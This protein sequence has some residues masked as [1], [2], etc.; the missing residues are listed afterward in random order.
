MDYSLL[1]VIE[2][3]TN[4]NLKINKKIYDDVPRSRSTFS[5][6]FK[7]SVISNYTKYPLNPNDG[8]TVI[9]STF[10]DT[11]LSNKKVKLQG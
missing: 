7:D 8:N 1:L 3:T 2:F 4:E 5:N 11:S 6:Y 9:T 10:I